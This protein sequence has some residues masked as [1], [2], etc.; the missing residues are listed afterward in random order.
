MF[1][2]YFN[3]A[4]KIVK[5]IKVKVILLDVYVLNNSLKIS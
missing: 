1:S 5:I 3:Y 4:N 2:M